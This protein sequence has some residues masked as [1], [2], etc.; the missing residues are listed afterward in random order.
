MPKTLLLDLHKALR[1]ALQPIGGSKA[2]DWN[3]IVASQAISTLWKTSNPAD[4][5]KREQG[6][7]VGMICM[8]P[9]DE[10]EGMLMAQM[11]GTHNAAME[12]HRRAM[13]PEQPFIGRSEALTQANKLSR[14]FATL[15]EAL[16]RHRGKGQQ[17]VTVEHVHVHAG[18]QAVVGVVEPQG[19]GGLR[20]LEEQPYAVRGEDTER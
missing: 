9:H 16:N 3:E 1:G 17:K 13:L 15:L 18:G 19:A 10:F 11:I 4:N 8:K 5:A 6:I 14:T 2:D 7:L 20:K 12:C